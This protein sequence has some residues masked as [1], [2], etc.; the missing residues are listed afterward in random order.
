MVRVIIEDGQIRPLGPLPREW[1]DGRKLVIQE[2]SDGPAATGNG[3]ALEEEF[4][5][6]AAQWKDETRFLSFSHKIAMNF[7]YQ[8]IIGMGHD[9]LPLILR[10]LQ[11]EPH[12]WFWALR[13]ITGEDPVPPESQGK[14]PEM[15][16]AWIR[17][18]EE[19][20]II[21]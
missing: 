20:G 4:V 6:L 18:A 15:V 13:A 5:R 19:H 12:H 11:K 10:E 9:V 16:S 21:Q 8:R 3:V 1:T 2:T 7:A 17:W 14:I